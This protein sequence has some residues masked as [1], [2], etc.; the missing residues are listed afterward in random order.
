MRMLAVGRMARA[1]EIF[2]AGIVVGEL[3]HELHERVRRVRRRCTD[4]VSAVNWRHK[5]D[6]PMDR[7]YSQG[8]SVTHVTQRRAARRPPACPRSSMR[9]S[10]RASWPAAPRG[11]PPG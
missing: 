10:P 6:C 4:G 9:A 5:T 11:R 3:A 2:E 8:I 1:P 7:L